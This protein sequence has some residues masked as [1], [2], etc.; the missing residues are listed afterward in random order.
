M[1]A[2]QRLVRSLVMLGALLGVLALHGLSF[3]SEEPV[4]APVAQTATVLQV[5]PHGVIERLEQ[6]AMLAP[7][8]FAVDAPDHH[9]LVPCLAMAGSLL[10]LLCVGLFLRRERFG[11]APRHATVTLLPPRRRVVKVA[12][13]LARLCI[14]RT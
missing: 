4:A 5:D 1:N 11:E 2:A 6:V 9:V 8:T 7:D 14:L 10:L 12:P 3:S 13:D